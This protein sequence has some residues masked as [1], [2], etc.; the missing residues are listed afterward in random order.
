[1][2]LIGKGRSCHFM[3]L[4]RPHH[5][6][7]CKDGSRT[8]SKPAKKDLDR[9]IVLEADRQL[10][11]N[12][13]SKV[14]NQ[15]PYAMVPETSDPGILILLSRNLRHQSQILQDKNDTHVEWGRIAGLPLSSVRLT[16]KQEIPEVRYRL[17]Y[18]KAG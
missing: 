18:P 17:L 2:L 8:Q 13:P 9:E 1:M 5:R 10:Y 7:T 12:D 11:I 4:S 16:R 15:G 6:H 14:I 3:L